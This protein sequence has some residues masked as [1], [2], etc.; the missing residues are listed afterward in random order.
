MLFLVTI[1]LRSGKSLAGMGWFLDQCEA[2]TQTMADWPE[3]ERVKTR[4]LSRRRPHVI[5][6]GV[7]G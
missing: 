2:V 5:K 1:K 4:C 7:R 3:A 6:G